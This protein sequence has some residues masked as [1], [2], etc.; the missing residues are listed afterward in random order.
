MNENGE[1][2]HE[3]KARVDYEIKRSRDS[4][5]ELRNLVNSNKLEITAMKLDHSGEIN[6]LRLEVVIQAS[7]IS[8]RLTKVTVIQ[9]LIIS[10]LVFALKVLFKV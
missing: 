10:A 5:H 9:T 2:W 6:K 8:E 4:I 1:T 3:A 7:K